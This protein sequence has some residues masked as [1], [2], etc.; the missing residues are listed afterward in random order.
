MDSVL[1]FCLS[2]FDQ[3]RDNDDVTRKLVEQVTSSVDWVRCV[4]TADSLQSSSNP[5]FLEVGGETL[6]GFV[7]QIL[8]DSDTYSINNIEQLKS[9]LRSV[10]SE[11]SVAGAV[12][13]LSEKKG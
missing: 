4:K 10:N 3:T 7:K 8:P 1:Y 12:R 5:T 11:G 13:A 2:D 9:F 6:G